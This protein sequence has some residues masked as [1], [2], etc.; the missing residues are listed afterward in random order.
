M[1]RTSSRILPAKTWWFVLLVV[2]PLGS[3]EDCSEEFLAES[4]RVIFGSVTDEKAVGI[5]GAV[6]QLIRIFESQEPLP[7]GT[8]TT[9]GDGSYEFRNLADGR[10]S[11][12]ATASGR[13]CDPPR[14]T[15]VAGQ[16]GN[17]PEVNFSCRPL[18]GRIEGR[19]TVNGT[20]TQASVSLFAGTSFIA[21][22]ETDAGGS[23]NFLD[24]E[25]GTKQ[26]RASKPG[27]DCGTRDVSV[28]SQQATLADLVCTPR[29]ASVTVT[30]ELPGGTRVP[31]ASVTISGPGPS[32][33]VGSGGTVSLT[34]TGTTGADGKVM[35][36]G[37]PAGTYQITVALPNHSCTGT[38]LTVLP[39]EGKEFTS[40]C[41]PITGT[42]II[43]L[44]TPAGAGIAN[45]PVRLQ[46]PSPSTAIS[47]PQTTDAQGNATFIVPPGS[48]TVL[49]AATALGFSCPTPVVSVG[50]GATNTSTFTCTSLP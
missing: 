5:P 2:L 33:T 43:R 15:T 25:P 6:I 12:S 1:R 29:P 39:G 40:G 22:V 10:Y 47:A 9:A 31:G 24:V 48:Y 16:G 23:Y 27:H 32:G 41:T 46:G 35:F 26:V 17:A 14:I 37:L 28:V 30:V 8:R 11:V 38:S 4:S 34:Q 42:V 13:D 7:I 3:C 21:T 20:G 36:P 50:A 49:I 19:V 44:R 45:V 18:T